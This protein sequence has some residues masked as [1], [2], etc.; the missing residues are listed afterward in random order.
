MLISQGTTANRGREVH[1]KGGCNFKELGAFLWGMKSLQIT[2][3][4]FVIMVS[5]TSCSSW[6]FD[7]CGPFPE[8][9]NW[10]KK[11]Y[12]FGVPFSLD[13]LHS[14]T[15]NIRLRSYGYASDTEVVYSDQLDSFSITVDVQGENYED[16]TAEETWKPYYKYFWS[17]Q[18]LGISFVGDYFKTQGKGSQNP[19]CIPAP[20]NVLNITKI[21]IEVPKSL[22]HVIIDMAY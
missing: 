16:K 21:K 2:P 3:L 14:D 5:I 9:Y 15:L 10:E 8:G 6:P 22:K 13:S 11:D 18:E 19:Q 20:Y 12:Q 17:Q 4:L 7:D 1:G